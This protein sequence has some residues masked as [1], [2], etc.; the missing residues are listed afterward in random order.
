MFGK[1]RVMLDYDKR[2]FL[3][4]G[5][6]YVVRFF[7]CQDSR[8][9]RDLILINESPGAQRW[10]D[11]VSNL[12]IWHYRKWMDE[13]GEGNTFLFAIADPREDE[14]NDQRVH[15][16]I[17]IYPSK[18]ISGRLE[19]S[20]AKRPNAPAG[21]TVPAIFEVLKYVKEYLSEKKPWMVPNLKILAEIEKGNQ[22]SILVAERA[23]FKMI[24]EY[25]EENNGLWGRELEIE[26]IKKVEVVLKERTPLDGMGRV[27]QEHESF[28]GPATLQI[29]LS[30]FGVAASQE[31]LI[32]AATTKEHA[33]E[34]G[35]SIELLAK[36]VN[37]L[38]PELSFWIKRD[39]SLSDIET[40]VRVY[41]Y[42]VGVDWQ[43]IFSDDGT[44]KSYFREADEIEKESV[45]KGDD[46]HYCV[47]T[48]VD[49]ANDK[50]RMMDPYSDFFEND[51]FFKIQDFI[52]RWW[53]DRMDK[54]PDGSD[55]YVFE[56]RLMFV[57]VP[58]NVR[59]PEGL[60]MIEL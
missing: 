29:L 26:E 19:I 36:S 37:N 31:K 28:C 30:H 38:Y 45:C 41:N 49:K 8:D 34:N 11:N 52:N 39:A 53:D 47:I 9:L 40:M 15:G 42:P 35:M 55:K 12:H 5:K 51:R 2:Y 22:A 57:I 23:G 1:I 43:G 4:D 59:L 7:E 24:R 25:D 17:Y 32:T 33:V 48:D 46:G 27:R 14:S 13:K 3:K 58:K 16:F 50:I 18:I 54:N 60:G 10:M 21:L 20:Y 44:V 56:K 6:G